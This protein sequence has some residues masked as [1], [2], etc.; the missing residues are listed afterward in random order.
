M[1]QHCTDEPTRGRQPV[2]V[3]ARLG[4]FAPALLGL[5]WRFR[6]DAAR[7]KRQLCPKSDARPGSTARHRHINN[8]TIGYGAVDLSDLK[9]ASGD[10]Q[11]CTDAEEH[12]LTAKPTP[13]PT[14]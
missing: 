2:G 9:D 13:I 4:G 1:P 8:W 11:P 5:N 3:P 12:Q 10:A 14:S 7:R 6:G